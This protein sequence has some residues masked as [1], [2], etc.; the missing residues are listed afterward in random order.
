MQFAVLDVRS[1]FSKGW[2]YPGNLSVQK[3]PQE[4]PLLIWGQDE[5]IEKIALTSQQ[6]F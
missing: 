6:I 3:T 1:L 2:G 4:N 5:Y